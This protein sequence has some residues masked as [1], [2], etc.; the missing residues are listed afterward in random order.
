MG[1]FFIKNSARCR[2]EDPS[3]TTFR[4]HAHDS[5]EIFY[6][7]SGDAFYYVEGTPYNLRPGDIMLMRKSESHVLS[8]RSNAPYERIV[9]NFD[10]SVSSTG[11]L[12]KL[13]RVFNDRPL[14]AFN[15]YSAALFPTNHWLYYLTKICEYNGETEYQISFLLPLLAELSE[16]F[17][18]VKKL[19]QVEEPDQIT[20]I[21][22]YI[23]HNITEELSLASL[24]SLFYM[25]QAHM[26][27]IFKKSTGSTVWN[28]IVIKRLLLAREML[29]AGKTPTEVYTFCGF[30]DYT[31][32]FRA[33]KKH[34][35]IS[36]KKD[37]CQ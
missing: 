23:N 6:F 10:V 17:D 4:M 7:L 19:K 8:L 16:C 13:L 27:R 5:Y 28:Y 12:S 29:S 34:F 32:F 1:S 31:T 25:S 36:P 9:V 22:G 35:G 37:Q 2:L 21:I 11:E 24:C 33:Y 18:S 20:S 26:N 3:A 15:H 14:G 30:Q